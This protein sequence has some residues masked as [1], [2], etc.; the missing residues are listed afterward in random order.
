M[1]RALVRIQTWMVRSPLLQDGQPV[2]VDMA[3][4]IDGA[5]CEMALFVKIGDEALRLLGGFEE[6]SKRRA[7]VTFEVMHGVQGERLDGS[8][9]L[10]Q[11]SAL[12]AQGGQ[13]DVEPF[14]LNPQHG[15]EEFVHPEVRPREHGHGHRV[16]VCTESGPHV[17]IDERPL[18]TRSGRL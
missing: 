1:F 18:V 10:A 6:Q 15:R 7:A 4:R 3:V 12:P 16:G 8:E 17:V 9:F 14:C 5:N 13:D 2:G 11:R